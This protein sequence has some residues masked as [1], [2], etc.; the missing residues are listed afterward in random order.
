[1]SLSL[2]RLDHDKVGLGEQAGARIEVQQDGV[3]LASY[4]DPAEGIRGWLAFDGQDNPLAAGGFRVQRGLTPDKVKALAQ[5]M[6]LKQRLLGLA[7]DG[8]KCGIDYD[9]QSPG[10][11]DAMRR[12]LRCLRPFLLDRFSM[13][14]DMGT[15]WSEI[16]AIARSEGV[17]SVKIA[18][19]K[20]QGLTHEDVLNR[21]RLLA[22][23]VG[24]LT[25]GQRR[26]GHGLAHAALAAL[27]WLHSST[28]DGRLRVGV[29][30]FG[31][32]G[33]AAALSLAEA[34]LRVSAVA[35]EHRCLLAPDGVDVG[36]LLATPPGTPVGSCGL[37]GAS[38][39]R[40]ALFEVAV[41]LL[42]LAACEEAMS[43]GEAL[44]VPDRVKVV[45]VGANLGLAPAVEKLLYRRGIAVV[46]DFV[47]GCGGSASMNALF[48]PPVCPS[49]AEFLDG[50]AAV[51]RHLVHRILDA[52]AEGGI[53]PRA[54][55]LAL[56]QERQS[57][58]CSRPYAQWEK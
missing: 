58:A 11:R 50:T 5:A 19:A 32:L 17:P 47:G 3:C 25:L 43:L 23:T 45:A 14:P 53:S 15:V 1:M 18:I 33:R 49:A 28:L 21:L 34:G 12:F 46:P 30:G 39:P 54:A 10:K 44:R 41:D 13:G 56:S 20:A 29:Q 7:V 42:V 22:I 52:A 6:S 8:A 27:G 31:T 35:D 57:D 16:E 38:G 40:E 4:L 51:I 9:P 55:A 48:G 24:G 36:A 37:A 2:R 26:A